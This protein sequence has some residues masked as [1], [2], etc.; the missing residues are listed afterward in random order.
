MATRQ[1]P[2]LIMININFK[3]GTLFK[4]AFQHTIKMVNKSCFIKKLNFFQ[5]RI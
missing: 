4:R 5:I 2:S 1:T 3:G